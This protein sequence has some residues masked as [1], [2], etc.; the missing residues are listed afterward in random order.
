MAKAAK[1]TA[2]DKNSDVEIEVEEDGVDH[3]NL[4]PDTMLTLDITDLRAANTTPNS[5]WGKVAFDE[6]GRATVKVPFKDI[7]RIHELKW[8][9]PDD[10]EK[11]LAIAPPDDSMPM[12]LEAQRAISELEAHKATASKLALKNAEL[13]AGMEMQTKRFDQAY[14]EYV[15]KSEA[16]IADLQKQLELSQKALNDTNVAFAA[17]QASQ[18]KAAADD[19]VKAK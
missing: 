7:V 3:T 6:H 1:S 18:P 14:G 10:Q 17:L 13:E 8:L 12:Q 16:Q 9:S 19:K 15:K 5:R 4:D 2:E 11:Y